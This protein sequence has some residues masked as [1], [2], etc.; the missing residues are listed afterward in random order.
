MTQMQL[1]QHI[2]TF[3]NFR[4]VKFRNKLREQSFSLTELVDLTFHGDPQVAQKASK[5]LQYIIF[6][7]PAN[8]IEE[9][10]YLIEHVTEV[11][12]T[13]CRRHY[14]KILLHLTSP[15]IPKEVRNKVKELDF[16]P[17]VELCFRWLND[18]KMT[19][20]IRTSAAETLFNLRHRYPSIAEA[21]SREL[22][23]MMLYM[24]P[25]LKQ[26]GNYILSFLHCED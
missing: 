13:T 22:E 2:S 6:K 10:G 21:L 26:K 9:I 8:Y 4:A 18:S 24:S 12:C 20:S 11:D 23:A 5:I 19:A 17:I 14:A 25:M 7:F 1:I 3:D 16:E 15:E